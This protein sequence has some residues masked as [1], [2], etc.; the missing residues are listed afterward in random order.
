[1]GT[2]DGRGGRGERRKG[3]VEM[4]GSRSHVQLNRFG[5]LLNLLLESFVQKFS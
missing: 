2:G 1:M 5:P 3:L 4:S